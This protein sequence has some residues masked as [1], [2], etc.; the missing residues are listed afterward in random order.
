MTVRENIGF[1][2]KLRHRPKAEIAER[3]GEAAGL[4]EITDYLDRKPRQLSGGQRQRVA[5][6]RAI[7]REASAFLFDEPLSNLDAK[8]RA[9]TRVELR[10]IADKVGGTYVYVT[11]DQVEAVTLADRIAIMNKG[12]LIQVGPPLE[13]YTNP[14]DVFVASFIGS[15]PM[16]LVDAVYDPVEPA[17]EVQGHRLAVRGVEVGVPAGPVTLGIRPENLAPSRDGEPVHLSA[18][19]EV[20]ELVGSDVY[21]YLESEGGQRLTARA[22]ARHQA[23]AGDKVPL[24]IHEQMTLFDRESG[25]RV[26]NAAPA[27]VPQLAA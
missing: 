11:H 23:R 26:S 22:P 19:V 6:A 10:R 14:A 25:K 5:V 7:V 17:I 16:G 24:T 8:L 12:E 27:E 9:Q 13:V 21:L 2:L 1:S 18:V 4:L 3:V 15:P 20:S